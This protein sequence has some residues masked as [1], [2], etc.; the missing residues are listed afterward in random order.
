MYGMSRCRQGRVSTVRHFIG[1]L[2]NFKPGLA[3]H[4]VKHSTYIKV[5]HCC[6]IQQMLTYRHVF[7]AFE[8]F[9]VIYSIIMYNV[10]QLIIWLILDI[11]SS[12]KLLSYPTSLGLDKLQI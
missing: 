6:E 3:S 9:I 11:L 10:K 12:W 2:S 7:Y 5:I 8:I 1:C 4:A